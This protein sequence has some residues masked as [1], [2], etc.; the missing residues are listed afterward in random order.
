MFKLDQISFEILNLQDYYPTVLFGPRVEERDFEGDGDVP[1]FYIS[2]N[3]NEM[4]LHNVMLDSRV[5]HNLMPQAIMESLG[6]DITRPY[7]KLYSFDSKKVKCIGLIKGMVITL[8]QLPT[9]S[10]VMDV[11]VADI[12]VKFG[13]LLS[14]SW[15]AKLKGT[16]QMDLSYATIPVF[17]EQRRL[18]K[19][20]RL[21][22]MASNKDK[23]INY[24]IYSMEIELGSSVFYNHE[25]YKEENQHQ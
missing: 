8:T 10:L 21:A 15:S 6:L 12:P 25:L 3:I 11:M 5:S 24:P 4:I 23:S 22:Y 14:R 1:P 7:S 9:K 20:V 18:Y 17:G 19:E 2:L 13:M 16:L